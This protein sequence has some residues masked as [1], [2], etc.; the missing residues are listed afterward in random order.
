LITVKVVAL[1]PGVICMLTGRTIND[2]ALAAPP[3][4]RAMRIGTSPTA[5]TTRRD[6]IVAAL[7]SVGIIISR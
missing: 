3:P 7:F 4:R 2:C 1:C 5:A 6:V